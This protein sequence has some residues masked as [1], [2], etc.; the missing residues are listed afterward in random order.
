MAGANSQH[1]KYHLGGVRQVSGG[2][3]LQHTGTEHSVRGAI[4]TMCL[5]PHQQTP[6]P[7]PLA[8]MHLPL[9]VVTNASCWISTLSCLL[10]HWPLPDIVG[11]ESHSASKTHPALECQ[12]A[13]VFVAV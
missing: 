8:S 2:A 12:Q 3:E 7:L 4:V 11:M 13:F 9:V 10:I 5:H 6:K 1:E